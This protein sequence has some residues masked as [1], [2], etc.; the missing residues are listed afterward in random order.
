MSPEILATIFDECVHD[1][2][3]PVGLVHLFRMAESGPEYV[4]SHT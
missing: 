2:R 1:G 4:V 3:A